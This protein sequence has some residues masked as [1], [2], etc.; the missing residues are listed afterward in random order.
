MTP[1]TCPACGNPA[2]RENKMVVQK[3]E[4]SNRP[5]LDDVRFTVCMHC[6]AVWIM[7]GEPGPDTVL[8]APTDTETKHLRPMTDP[9]A[10][11]FRRSNL[12]DTF[13]QRAEIAG[14]LE[15]EFISWS[16]ESNPFEIPRERLA[17]YKRSVAEVIVGSGEY[18]HKLS[19]K[20]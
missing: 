12:V 6:Q 13:L 16:L 10:E 8:R 14:T 11:G 1:P 18:P 15:Q 3:W 19:R 2:W 20:N 17:E 9:V 5:N 4:I 7:S